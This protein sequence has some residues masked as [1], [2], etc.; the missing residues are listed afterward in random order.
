MLGRRWIIGRPPGR[1]FPFI[2]GEHIFLPSVG[3]MDQPKTPDSAFTQ[4]GP[5]GVDE[6]IAG[7]VTVIII[8]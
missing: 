1:S 4:G 3:H 5:D 2:V 7:T 6:A 8:D